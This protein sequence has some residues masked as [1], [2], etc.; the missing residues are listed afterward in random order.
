[1]SWLTTSG[2][3]LAMVAGK[4]ALMYVTALLGL[5]LSQRRTLAQLTVFDFVAAVAVGAIVGRTAIAD[6]QS[7]AAGAVALVTILVLHQLASLLRFHPGLN[8]LTDHRVRVLVVDGQLRR[9]QLR[10]S[11]LTDNDLYAELRLR[12]VFDLDLVRYALY[13]TKGGITV[14]PHTPGP[15]PPLVDAGLDAVE[16]KAT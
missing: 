16:E 11:G 7:Y 1:M 9:H 13:E 4:A 14:V 10:R 3:V 12:G 6:G 15:V 2:A 8:K 5:R